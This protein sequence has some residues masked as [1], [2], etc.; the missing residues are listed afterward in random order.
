MI[1][2][3]LSLAETVG[4]RG[5]EGSSMSHHGKGP[6]KGTV[7]NPSGRPRSDVVRLTKA[8]RE[9]FDRQLA[10]RLPDIFTALFEAGTQDRDTQALSLLVQRAVPVRKGVTV[11][12]KTRPLSNPG[13]CAAAFGDILEAIGHGE[14]TP[15]E[16]NMIGALI[17]RRANLFHSLEV[18]RS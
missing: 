11:N 3:A 5:C 6:A 9:R 1:P 8:A 7:N 18:R 16:G 2:H 12:F 17:E 4:K 15:E 13:E 10:E 14:L